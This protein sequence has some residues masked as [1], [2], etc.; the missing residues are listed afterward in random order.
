LVFLCGLAVGE[1]SCQF[2]VSAYSFQMNKISV[3]LLSI[4]LF[5]ADSFAANHGKVSLRNGEVFES[6]LLEVSALTGVTLRHR[7]INEPIRIKP[8]DLL[9]I[10]LPALPVPVLRNPDAVRVSLVDGGELPGNLL[11]LNEKELVLG[12]L[13]GV[14]LTISRTNLF[15]VNWVFRNRDLKGRG[16]MDPQMSGV[17]LINGDNFKGKIGK[18]KDGWLSFESLGF[19]KI[20]IPMKK[21]SYLVLGHKIDGKWISLPAMPFVETIGAITEFDHQ[22]KQVIVKAKPGFNIAPKESLGVIRDNKLV[23]KI[24][25]KVLKKLLGQFGQHGNA[26][27]INGNILPGDELARIDLRMINRN[28]GSL[29]MGEDSVAIRM[30]PLGWFVLHKMQWDGKFLRGVNT[31]FGEVRLPLSAVSE[32]YFVT[33]E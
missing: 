12:M 30:R 4:L 8:D 31:Y 22:L 33:P 16:N 7:L 25:I 14:R 11:G 13:P 27:W 20:N 19:G 5:G 26:D 18:I 32:V 6:E 29:S 9:A 2:P 28:L 24:K 1:K 21:I 17:F 23:G 15:S 10:Q 3:I